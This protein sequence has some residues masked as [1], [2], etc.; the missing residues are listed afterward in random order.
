LEGLRVL[1]LRGAGR[2]FCAGQDLEERRRAP[3]VA[4]ADLGESI[5]RN[6]APLIRAIRDFP[7]PV[8]AV[9]HGVAAGSGANVALASDMVI[10]ARSA[11]FVQPFTRIGLIPD[12][13]GG[14]RL[15]RVIGAAR[16]RGLTLLGEP[17]SAEQAAAW[18]LIWQCVD[19]D[20]LDT[21][22][23]SVVARLKAGAPLAIAATRSALNAG[24]HMSLEEY[25]QVEEKMQRDLGYTQDYAEGVTAFFEK[26]APEFNGR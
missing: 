26:R 24:A 14:W 8:I 25:L 13:G 23:A 1:V 21:E 6:Y 18:G 22:V 4:A 17:L 19:D 3:G 2:A 11:S 15:P 9:V 5:R 7:V 10:A 16:A 12:A 20:A